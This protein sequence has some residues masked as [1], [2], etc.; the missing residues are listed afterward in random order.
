MGSEEHV[1]GKQ[2]RG[3]FIVKGE[4]NAGIVFIFQGFI[5]HGA[6]QR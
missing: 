1:F 3:P 6:C 2:G 4:E 5:G